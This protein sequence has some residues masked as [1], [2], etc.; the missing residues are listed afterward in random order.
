MRTTR[1]TLARRSRTLLMVLL[2]VFL[3][4]CVQSRRLAMSRLCEMPSEVD[5]ESG[6]PLAVAAWM[7]ANIRNRSVVRDYRRIIDSPERSAEIA[8]L[9]RAE[10]IADCQLARFLA[11]LDAPVAPA[12]VD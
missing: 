5:L 11:R 9:A 12:E 4:S 7:D 1:S 8:A 2:P 10:G 6:E 3:C